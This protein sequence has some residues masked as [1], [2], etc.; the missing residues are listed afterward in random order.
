MSQCCGVI[1]LLPKKDKDPHF[2]KKLSSYITLLNTDYKIIAKV[3]ANRLK[4]ILDEIIHND[5]TGFLKGRNIGCNVRSIID[6]V[7]YCDANNLPGS[8][9][10]L[11]IEKAFDS[12]EHDYLFEVLKAFSLGS[13]SNENLP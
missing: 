2:I 5:Q 6:L 7:D 11:D 13:N 8:I 9:V 1:T 3:M 4:R 10:L 12:V